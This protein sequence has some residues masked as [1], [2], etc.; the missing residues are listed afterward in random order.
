MTKQTRQ[1]RKRARTRGKTPR[2]KQPRVPSNELVT[3]WHDE[4]DGIRIARDAPASHWTAIAEIRVAPGTGY[5]VPIVQQP[6]PRG[7]LWADRTK[8]RHG[9]GGPNLIYGPI[10][11]R[12]HRCKAPFTWTA[13]AQKHLYETIGAWTD[14]VANLCQPCARARRAIEDARAAYATARAAAEVAP[15]AA[16]Y[17]LVGK[18]MLELLEAGGSASIERAIAYCSHARKLGAGAANDAI[19][20]KLRARRAA[21][22][23]R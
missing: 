12:C 22:A 8:Q 3:V 23:R 15:T 10:A 4:R 5:Y 11:R 6:L 14:V 19:D 21:A 2:D 1:K 16:A 7:F 18:R 13:R 17:A 9:W 20:A